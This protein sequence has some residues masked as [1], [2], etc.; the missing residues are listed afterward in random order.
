[1]NLDE[2]EKIVKENLSE[3][4]Y[5]HSVCVMNK[6]EELAKKYNFDVEMAKKV[7][8]THDIA[9][10]FT[11]KQKLDY[12][13]KHHLIIDDIERNNLPLLHAKIG[14]DIAKNEFGFSNE[15]CNAILY[16]STAREN[17]TLLE[18]ILYISDWCGDDR[19]FEEALK[20]KEILANKGLDIAILF[21]LDIIVN[22]LLEKKQPMH[23]NTIKARNYLLKEMVK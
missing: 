21:T 20:A 22:E 8:I 14:A 7:G 1:M 15:M 16:H 13:E 12:V 2:L 11:D 3:K 5:Y 6:C 4:R 9:K 10:E 23:L 19:N 18:K 17:M